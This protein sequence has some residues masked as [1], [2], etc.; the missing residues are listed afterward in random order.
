[1][2][3]IKKICENEKNAKSSSCS[4]KIENDENAISSSCSMKHLNCCLIAKHFL[5]FL[6]EFLADDLITKQS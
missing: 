4:I 6:N 2:C 1:M 3:L 5:I